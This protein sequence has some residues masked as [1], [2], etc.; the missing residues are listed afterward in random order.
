MTKSGKPDFGCKWGRGA[1]AGLV[2]VPIRGEIALYGVP[3]SGLPDETT[4]TAAGGV[5]GGDLGAAGR[6]HRG[7]GAVRAGR[8]R[9]ADR[10][11]IFPGP[12]QGQRRGVRMG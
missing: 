11:Q 3:G 10:S 6:R 12:V 4:Y 5:A 1:G 9:R 2:A 7:A 8:V